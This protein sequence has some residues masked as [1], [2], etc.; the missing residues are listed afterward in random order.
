MSELVVM[1]GLSG[2]GK[3]YLAYKAEKELGYKLVSSDAIRAEFGDVN[4]QSHNPDVFRTFYKR[5]KKLLREK[6]NVIADAT[7][8]NLKDRRRLMREVN[9]VNDCKKIIVVVGRTFESCL[10]SNSQRDRIVPEEV[11]YSQRAKFQVP[12]YEEGWDEIY[13]LKNPEYD[14]DY[15]ID[16]MDG[17]DQK[18]PHHDHDLLTHCKMTWNTYGQTA[19]AL[20][21]DYGKLFTQTFD[22]QG[23]A[24]YYRHESVG[25][26]EVMTK[27]SDVNLDD[28]FLINYHMMPFGWES[29]KAKRKWQRIFGEKKYKMLVDFNKCDKEA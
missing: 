2:S 23:I 15:F 24:H 7:F 3:S 17:F 14:I 26:Y 27:C 6:N 20:L 10:R 29:D 13:I 4:D 1:C 22:E 12:F 19:G 9:K 8:L 21:H 5:M 18:N 25:A 16:K 28:L 11:I